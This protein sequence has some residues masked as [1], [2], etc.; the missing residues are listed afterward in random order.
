MRWLDGF[1]R[2]PTMTYLVHGEQEA[3]DALH[4]KITTR[5]WP[6]H[7]ARHLERVEL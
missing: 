3:L 2:P 5:G 6:V 1:I 4:T 7:I